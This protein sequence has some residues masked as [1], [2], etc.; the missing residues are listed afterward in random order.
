[1]HVFIAHTVT[2]NVASRPKT[3]PAPQKCDDDIH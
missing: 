1:V 2:A 3:L